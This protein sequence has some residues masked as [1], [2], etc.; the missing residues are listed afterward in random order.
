MNSTTKLIIVGIG[1]A[2]LFSKFGPMGLVIMALVMFF[3]G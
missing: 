3:I 2:L 1:G